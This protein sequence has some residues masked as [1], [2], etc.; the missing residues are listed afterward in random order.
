MVIRPAR[1]RR[2]TRLPEDLEPSGAAGQVVV[3]VVKR[4]R[5]RFRY[6]DLGGDRSDLGPGQLVALLS[7][8]PDIGH[9]DPGRGCGHPVEHSAR[10]PGPPGLNPILPITWSY[11]SNVAPLKSNTIATA[12]TYTLS[13]EEEHGCNGHPGR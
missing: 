7:E 9:S 1:K 4:H 13:A 10:A 6:S 3:D 8:L 2:T 12:I 5:G 11:C